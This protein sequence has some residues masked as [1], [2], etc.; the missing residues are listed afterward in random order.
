MNRN[1]LGITLD[2]TT[3]EGKDLVKLFIKDAD[4]VI[5]NYTST[6]TV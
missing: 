6:V 5:E 2:L 1:K 3:S 4:A